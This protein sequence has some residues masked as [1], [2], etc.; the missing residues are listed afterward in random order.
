MAVPVQ[1][2]VV[3]PDVYRIAGRN[4]TLIAHLQAAVAVC[5]HD[6][7]QGIGGLL[8]LRFVATLNNQPLELTDNT[9][10]SDILLLD[11]FCKELKTQGARMQAWRIRIIAHT[12]PTE[13]L[14]HP[15]ATVL[16][17]L[18]AY[19]A[20]ARVAP[21]I[22]EIKRSQ[23]CKLSFDAHEGRIWVNGASSLFDRSSPVNSEK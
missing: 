21:E 2:I 11:R 14:Q 4:A 15:I 12:P 9:L 20:D 17:L 6:D 7:T 22:R 19:F 3:D 18:R 23:L 1:E 16:D 5:V 8:H 13:G 10:S